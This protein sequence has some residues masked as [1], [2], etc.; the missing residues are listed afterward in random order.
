MSAPIVERPPSLYDESFF[1][2]QLIG[3]E[4]IGSDGGTLTDVINPTTGEVLA[5]TPDGTAADAGAAVAA[6]LAAGPSWAQTPPV[7]R[8]K[9]LRAI[10]DLL[11]QDRETFARDITL[12]VGSP[13][14]LARAFQLGLPLRA[15][16]AAADLAEAYR[17]TEDLDSG[18]ILRRDA[19]G[20]TVAI[21]PWNYPLHQAVAKIAY[22]LA[23]GCTLVLKPSEV[24]PLA[25]WRF[26]ELTRAVGLPGGVFNIVGGRGDIVGEALVTHPDV[27]VVAV[28]GSTRTGS[29]VAALASQSVKR[30]S[31]ELG[32]KGAD[33][34]LADADPTAVAKAAVFG[35]VLNSGQS[36]GALTRLLV[37][38]EKLG[39]VEASA[40]EVAARVTVGDP[41]DEGTR[42]GP[43]VSAAQRDRVIGFL[44]SAASQGARLVAGGLDQVD[45][46]TR[47]YF[48]PVTV[49]SDV[50]E[51]MDVH[52]QEIFGPVLS[53]V[54][55]DDEDDAV[56]IANST[57]Y[58][59]TAGVW[60]SNTDRAVEV[61]TRL[62]AGQV[63]INGKGMD[64]TAPFGGHKHSG[65]G[66]ENGV[67]GLEEFL[68]TK[69]IVR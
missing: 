2:R 66:R 42:M 23:A 31:L 20:V 36:C 49:L 1:G 32:G 56:R 24:A 43:L 51:S 41:L 4:W 40:A 64:P 67:M 12:D 58:G 15:L 69:T 6:A 62:E 52:N 25:I 10:A 11:E 54:A 35:V 22:A 18:S 53:I 17:F 9:Q 37:P 14:K 39:E 63:W 59:L 57:D 26:G 45:T 68:E 46:N 61:A 19:A 21:T 50:D 65:L 47:G 3:G 33:V 5:Q 30:V 8:A 55:Y 7:Q 60:S 29:R 48:L 38:R 13:I 16:R 28:T 27:R 34:M 44:E